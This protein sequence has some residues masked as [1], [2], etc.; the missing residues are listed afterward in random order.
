MPKTEGG[1]GIRSVEDIA[2]TLAMK[3]WWRFRTQHS[4]L[5]NFLKAKYCS[6]SHPE[7][8]KV[9]NK[10]SQL[11][12]HMLLL[13]DKVEERMV[14]KIN[15]GESN[16]WWDNWLEKGAL[17]KS[18]PYN[19]RSSK[20][21]VKDYIING[22]WNIDRHRLVVPED[23]VRQIILI[24]IGEHDRSDYAVWMDSS[25]GHYSNKSAWHI[26]R[27]SSQ[28]NLEWNKIWHKSIPFKISFLAWRLYKGKL[29]F[30]EVINRFNMFSNPIRSRCY[31]C[32]NTQ[33]DL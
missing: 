13:R 25:D 9:A 10:D 18:I 24:D 6:R 31:C 33:S 27:Q 7:K 3:R 2:N 8:K 14:W 29:P 32:H 12:K 20:S 5:A 1:A 28:K 30:N 22:I 16:F 26:I 23:M 4:L 21:L 19:C 17:A 11:W 15:I